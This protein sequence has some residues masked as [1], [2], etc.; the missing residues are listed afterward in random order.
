MTVTGTAEM[1]LN[2][3]LWR[4]NMS[5]ITYGEMRVLWLGVM[6]AVSAIGAAV[7]GEG[8]LVVLALLGVSVTIFGVVWLRYKG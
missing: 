8:V 2:T 4:S 5:S 6:A 7:A 1:T 3:H